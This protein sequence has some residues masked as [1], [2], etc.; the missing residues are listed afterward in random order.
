MIRRPPRSTLFPYTTLFR[1]PAARYILYVWW[2]RVETD[3]N[4]L[5]VTEIGLASALVLLFNLGKV[6]WDNR[7]KVAMARLT[8]LVYAR[9]ARNDWLSRLRERA[10]VRSLP[11]A[12]D[13][14]VLTLTGHGTFVDERSPVR[15]VLRSAYEIRVMLVNPVGEGVRRRVESLPPEVTV[16]S[17]HGEIEASIAYLAELRKL[18]KKVTLKFYDEEPFWKVVVL[19]DHV[20]VQHC[21]HEI[22][23][24]HV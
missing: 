18:G 6:A 4:L 12:R 14:C 13:A 9:N 7:N 2:P 20:W 21:H 23:R 11:A 22:G 1:S 16:L 5:L 17:F 10:L 19:G 15:E 24:A 8:A 3:T